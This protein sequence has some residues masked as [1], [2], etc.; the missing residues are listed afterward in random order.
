MYSRWL[1]MLR[2]FNPHQLLKLKTPSWMLW[3]NTLGILPLVALIKCWKTLV[4]QKLSEC[5]EVRP[6]CFNR[7]RPLSI[8]LTV[9]WDGGLDRLQKDS[10]EGGEAWQSNQ[11]RKTLKGADYQTM[12]KDACGIVLFTYKPVFD[13]RQASAHW[14]VPPH[15]VPNTY[16]YKN[17]SS[18]NWKR[19][20]PARPN[21]LCQL[22]ATYCFQQSEPDDSRRR[23]VAN[24]WDHKDNPV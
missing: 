22:C 15:S 19:I 2:P 18:F 12:N 14:A 10:R 4:L 17:T 23:E 24:K 20:T 3:L 5:L 1:F 11:K 21:A 16:I 13:F 7:E 6:L 8:R 9:I